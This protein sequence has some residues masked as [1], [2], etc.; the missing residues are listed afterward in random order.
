MAI[1]K[2]YQVLKHLKRQLVLNIKKYSCFM[3]A[4]D[5]DFLKSE[6]LRFIQNEILGE[7]SR[8]FNLK[9][10]D[11]KNGDNLNDILNA[12][13]VMPFMADKTVIIARDFPYEILYEKKGESGGISK[14]KT[15][16]ESTAVI[17]YNASLPVDFKRGSKAEFVKN[18]I[19]KFGVFFDCVKLSERELNEVISAGAK[20][21]GLIIN[22][23]V[24]EHLLYTSGTELMSLQSELDKLQ[25][26]KNSS[27]NNLSEISMND[28]DEICRKCPEANAFDYAGAV[29]DKRSE[30]AFEI[31]RFSVENGE[32]MQ[33]LLGSII[34]QFAELYRIKIYKNNGASDSEIA[35]DFYNGN[36]YRL[37]RPMQLVFKETLQGIKEKINILEKTDMSLKTQMSNKASQRLLFELMTVKLLNTI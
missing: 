25:A 9:N 2:N 4:G 31:I 14:L 35:K 15:L 26:V 16:P 37:K 33:K 20:N 17:F 21:R 30:T 29:I 13:D 18:E 7:A 6:T 23:E 36:T 24:I 34:Y 5:D 1:I 12:A 3:I 8:E 32:D 27:T 10:F 19:D 11:F 28:I 22:G